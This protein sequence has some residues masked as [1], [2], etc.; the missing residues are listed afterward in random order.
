M[1][2]NA[3]NRALDATPRVTDKLF[4]WDGEMKL[5]AI[6]GSWRKRLVRPASRP[7]SMPTA[8]ITSYNRIAHCR[9]HFGRAG[10]ERRR[11]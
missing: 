4:F 9:A 2:G 8:E 5:D 6:V 10:P 1:S 7:E 11:L 3:N